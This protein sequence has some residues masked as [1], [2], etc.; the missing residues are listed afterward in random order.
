M[1]D[2]EKKK[3]KKTGGSKDQAGPLI[4]MFAHFPT[5]LYT[6]EEKYVLTAFTTSSRPPIR[7]YP[8]RPSI[9]TPQQTAHPC[10]AR[11]AICAH[12]AR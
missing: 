11:Q 3:S 5:S 1:P 10:E 2:H 6:Q 7:Q 8:I 12:A 9:P 4:S